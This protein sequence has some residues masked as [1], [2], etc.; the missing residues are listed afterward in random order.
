MGAVTIQ[1]PLQEGYLYNTDAILAAVTSRTKMLYLCSPNNPTGTYLTKSD[2]QHILDQLPSHVLVVLDA[3]YSHYAS[4]EDYTDGL[5][6]VRDGYPVLVLQTFSK[7]YGLA[8]VRVGFGA[9]PKEI[10]Q[11]ILQVKEPF[12]VNALAQAASIAAVGDDEHVRQSQELVVKE[13]QRFYE[14]FR[15]LGL[16]YTES[17]SNFV[18]VKLGSEAFALYEKL[19]AKGVIVRYG[20]IWGL[21]EHV[22]ITV[23]T[24][25]ENDRLITV[26]REVLTSS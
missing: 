10:I 9:A 14:A 18:L 24:P 2:F 6:F 22:R 25:E 16:E 26:L 8:G 12:N 11:S 17:M 21:P 5:E 23:G 4:A 1:V 3:A 13:R 20:R 7:I 15:Q 19:M